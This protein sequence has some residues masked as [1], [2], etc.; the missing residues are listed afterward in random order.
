MRHLQ[1][2]FKAFIAFV[3]LIALMMFLGSCGKSPNKY[4]YMIKESSG[5]TSY[6]DSYNEVNGCVTF[7]DE[8]DSPTK[9]CG[10]YTI[11]TQK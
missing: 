11:V 9:V 5:R 3:A 8:Q 10:T 4:K 2:P 7:T 6:A 1:N